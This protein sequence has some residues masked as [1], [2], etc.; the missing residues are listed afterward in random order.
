MLI[1]KELLVLN[2]KFLKKNNLFLALC[3][4]FW[5]FGFQLYLVSGFGPPPCPT[6]SLPSP[7]AVTRSGQPLH[8]S[9]GSHWALLAL[10]PPPFL[11][12]LWPQGITTSTPVS[13][14]VTHHPLLFL[15]SCI[16][17]WKQSIHS[18]LFS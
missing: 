18:V 10:F 14:L 2:D 8:H 1:E 13:S 11:F 5:C 3:P 17:L 7:R 16:H 9:S 4:T 15:Q 6:R 12:P